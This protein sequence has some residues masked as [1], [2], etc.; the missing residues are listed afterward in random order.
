[1]MKLD[2]VV[3]PSIEHVVQARDSIIK[4]GIQDGE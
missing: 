3:R 2:K 1:M 4:E